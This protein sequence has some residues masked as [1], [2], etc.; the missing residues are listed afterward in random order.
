VVLRRDSEHE[1]VTDAVEILVFLIWQLLLWLLFGCKE[2]QKQPEEAEGDL[3]LRRG[4]LAMLPAL[5][6]GSTNRATWAAEPSLCQIRRNRSIMAEIW[7]AAQISTRFQS[8]SLPGAGQPGA[9]RLHD[10]NLVGFGLVH[11]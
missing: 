10:P 4:S 2:Q 7:L 3:F 8:E 11:I 5:T 1:G 9:K 6:D